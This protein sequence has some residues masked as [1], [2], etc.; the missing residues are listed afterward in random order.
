MRK[1]GMG[2]EVFMQDFQRG[3]MGQQLLIVRI[4][5]HT[6]GKISRKFLVVS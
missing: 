3:I 5:P 1:E 2:Q 4:D 6:A